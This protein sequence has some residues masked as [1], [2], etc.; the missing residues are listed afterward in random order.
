M[1]ESFQTRTSILVYDVHTTLE[2]IVKLS[3]APTTCENLSLDDKFVGTCEI[4]L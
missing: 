3:L 2:T 1:H 4:G